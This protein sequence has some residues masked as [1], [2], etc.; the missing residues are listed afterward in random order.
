MFCYHSYLLDRKWYSFLMVFLSSMSIV[1]SLISLFS[2]LHVKFLLCCQSIFHKIWYIR[3]PCWVKHTL[4]SISKI[5]YEVQG[6]I[7][8]NNDE[9]YQNLYTVHLLSKVV[10]SLGII[11]IIYILP[12]ETSAWEGDCIFINVIEIIMSS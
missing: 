6:L 5:I 7:L 3:F 9:S 12:F 11:I 8:L 1:V 2:S 10:S 4:D